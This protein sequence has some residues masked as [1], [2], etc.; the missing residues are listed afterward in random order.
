MF[1]LDFPDQLFVIKISKFK[2]FGIDP[3]V[4]ARKRRTP[5]K[6]EVSYPF[7]FP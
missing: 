6:E 1:G 7:N 4:L 2:P 3:G 5:N